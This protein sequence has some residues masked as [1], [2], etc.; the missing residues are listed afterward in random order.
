[1]GTEGGFAPYPAWN[2]VLTT[3]DPARWGVY[4]AA[5]GNP[6]GDRWLPNEVDTVSVTPHFW[7]WNTRPERKPR[8]LEDL[9]D[10]YYRSVGHGAV[11][12]LNQTPDTSGLIPETD[13]RRAA[14]FGAEIRRR[15]GKSLA[16]NKGTG[17]LLELS[18]D[19]PTRIDHVITM[20]EIREGERVREYAVEAYVDGQWKEVCRGTAIGHQKID[21]FEP[22][23]TAR[24]RL[25]IDKS[26]AEP[27]IRR[28]AAFYVGG[29]VPERLPTSDWRFDEGRGESVQDASGKLQG[30]I[31][32]AAWK[33]E[34]GVIE[35]AFDGKSYVS[36]GNRDVFGSR[37]HHL[38]AGFGRKRH[39]PESVS[40]WPRI[41]AEWPRIS[42]AGTWAPMAGSGSP[43]RTK[44]TASCGP[45]RATRQ[46]PARPVE[47]RYPC[48]PGT[49]VRPLCQRQDRGEEILVACCVI[50]TTSTCGSAHGTQPKATARATDSWGRSTMS[51]FGIAPCRRRM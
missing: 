44:R 25:R 49:R 10:C 16:E 31:V 21:L 43:C 15:F 8:S 41:A 9:V 13:A 45:L 39:W 26:V 29:L 3:K 36:L 23:E 42:S 2:G 11:L 22:V 17:P 28:F 12:L 14:E 51:G 37:L 27:L 40:W 6:D 1:M 20:E 18:L 7:F 30:R 46:R 24:L 32:G 34:A 47:P 50:A 38:G 19:K 35:L 5:D 33:T 48:P 4:T